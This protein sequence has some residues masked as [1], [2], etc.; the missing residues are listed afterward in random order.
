MDAIHSNWTA[1]RM[2]SDGIYYADDFD[3]LTTILSALKWRKK[4]GR[5]KMITDSEGLRY[6][7]ERGM[8]GIWNEITTELDGI[9]DS[10][11][12]AVFW[13]AGKIYSLMYSGTPAA[14]MDTDFIVWDKLA[15]DNLGDIAVIHDEDIYPDVYPD[16]S[17]FNMKQGYIFDPDLNWRLRPANTAFYV[18]KNE[19]LAKLYTGEAVRFMENTEGGDNLTY[20]VFAEQR[21]LP[22]CSAM[23]GLNMYVISTLDRLF[24]DGERWF[25]HTWGMKRQMRENSALR[26]DFCRRCIRRIKADFPEYEDMLK[27]IEELRP[28]FSI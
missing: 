27:G 19:E 17:H 13:A 11:D 1:P 22:M 8:C 20:M 6:Y 16:I 25:T 26:A 28:Y 2:K 10:I 4:N 23:L 24:K 14:V 21:L 3:I 18:I 15:F 9:P 5:I 12:P 7:E